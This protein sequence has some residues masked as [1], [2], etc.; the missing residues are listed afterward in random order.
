M[1]KKKQYP[2]V[3][4]LKG[5]FI[6]LIVLHNTLSLNHLL[7]SVPGTAFI[8]LY[9]GQLGDSVF[10]MLS[11][12][13]FAHSYLERIRSG[14]VSFQQFMLRRMQKLYPLYLITNVA[15][16]GIYWLQYGIGAVPLKKTAFTLLLQMGGGLE[17]GVPYNA[18]TWFLS[19]LFVCYIAFFAIVCHAKKPTQY[20]CSIALAIAW[21]YFLSGDNLDVPFCFEGNGTAFLN[22][23]LGCAIASLLPMVNGKM[24]RWL[25][26][27]CLL[28]VC[29]SF[30]IIFRY[31]VEIASGGFGVACAFV[32]SPMILF[33]AVSGGLC[34]GILE[35]KPFTG[36]GKISV[37]I[38]FW[39]MVFYNLLSVFVP[40]GAVTLVQYV[41]YWAVLLLGSTLSYFVIERWI[42]G[43]RYRHITGKK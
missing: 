21:G 28:G 3:T 40:G 13:L 14:D 22:F 20:F 43:D 36:L 38:F 30:F 8:R 15:A 10:F 32:I 18:P 23:F 2:S 37:S 29:F 6:L 7:E 27:A 41:L 5:L 17:K 35:L 24:S 42:F 33:L 9:G 19:A 12:F 25:R 34:A 26:P 4:S 16:L 31:G 1:E 11:G 39:H